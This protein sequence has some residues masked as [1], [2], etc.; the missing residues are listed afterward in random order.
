[1]NQ[2]K[3]G[4]FL[5]EL[6]K[7]KQITQ[8]QLAEYLNVSNRS[9]SRW[10]TGN[11]LPDL[12]ILIQLSKYYDV[13]LIEILEG[14]KMKEEKHLETTVQKV[15]EY[16]YEEKLKLTRLMNFFFI[17]GVVS[18]LIYLILTMLNYTSI[19]LYNHIAMFFLGI[20]FGVLVVG[21]V[22]TSKYMNKIKEFKM[23][24]LNK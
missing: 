15:A 2:Q 9:V 19:E 21:V 5:K 20:S 18:N 7:E 13:Q 4:I 24:F 1:M 22:Y 23:K 11:N 10:E 17:L 6:R 3:I 8:E 12:D 16:G 14:E